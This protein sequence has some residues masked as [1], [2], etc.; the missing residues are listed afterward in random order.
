MQ[1]CP[2]GSSYARTSPT[3]HYVE[4]FIDCTN[5]VSNSL[6][7]WQATRRLLSRPSKALALDP[8]RRCD[9]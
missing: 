4:I 5:A 2:V 6:S 3:V 9:R 1:Q 7:I 8:D